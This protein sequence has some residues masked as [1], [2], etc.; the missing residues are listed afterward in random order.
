MR[1]RIRFNPESIQRMVVWKI[2]CIIGS[3][4]QNWNDNRNV[5]YLN[6]NW[7][8]NQIT[9]IQNFLSEK[10]KLTLH[11]NKVFIKTLSSGVDFL[12]WINFSD[13]RILRTTTKRRMMKRI[14]ENP[15]PE[16]INSYLGL[17][18]HGNA[19]QLY[20][21]IKNNFQQRLRRTY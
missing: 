16:T 2:L 17:M 5:P 21:I 12:G 15:T 1:C 10:L 11:P 19:N 13:H 9:S 8:K 4:W 14:Q 7:L 3:V 6:R 18:K 20:K